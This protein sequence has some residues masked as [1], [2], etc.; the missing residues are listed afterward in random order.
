MPSVDHCDVPHSAGL[1]AAPAL[2]RRV[3]H[4]YSHII[5]LMDEYLVP[6]T[7]AHHATNV[8]NFFWEKNI[9]HPPTYNLYF[10]LFAAL[11]SSQ[12]R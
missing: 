10:P 4:F 6:P 5:S 2:C 12:N 3:V 8:N 7:L 9:L 1:S 11:A